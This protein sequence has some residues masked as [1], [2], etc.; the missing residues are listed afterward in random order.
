[1]GVESVVPQHAALGRRVAY[2]AG[3][4]EGREKVA[5]RGCPNWRRG[6]KEGEEEKEGETGSG[7]EPRRPI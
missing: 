2:S 6:R 1:M 5:P 3:G 4:P 7:A